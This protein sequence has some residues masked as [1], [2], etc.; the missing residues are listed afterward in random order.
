MRLTLLSSTGQPQTARGDLAVTLGSSSPAGTFSTS[1]TGPWSPTLTLTIAAGAGTS[2]D[3]YYLDT[4]AG[5][6]LLTASAAGVTSG[7][8]TVT[9]TPG[10]LAS[11]VVSPAS[12][13]VRTRAAIAI[14]ASGKDTFGNTL[15]V[16][17]AWSLTPPT[18]GKLTPRTG[19]A[20][21]LTTLRATGQASVTATVGAL[22]A[23]AAVRVN[24]SR[25][26]IAY[27]TYRPRSRFV[28]VT[29]SAVDSAG[30]PISRAAVSVLVRLGDRRYFTGRGTTGAAGKTVVR[31]P[32]RA[33]GCF[34]TTIRAVSAPGFAWDGRTPMNRYCRR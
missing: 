30:R 26:R 13:T 24:P 25:L 15:P 14:T 33:A 3:F 1:P 19:P 34:R 8:Q 21:T 11:L 27:V 17:A 10:P 7:T 29:V 9:V 23:T 4:R 32:V 12:A 31:M 20:T 2:P 18:Y 22:S 16:S 5:A 6:Q 28:L